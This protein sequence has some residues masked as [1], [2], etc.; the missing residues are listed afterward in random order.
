[1][2]R[3]TSA[4]ISLV[5]AFVLLITVA[6]A[7][8]VPDDTIVYITPTGTKYHREDCS[9]TTTVRSMTIKEAESRGFDPCSRCDPDRVVGSYSSNWDGSNSSSG[10]SSSN[11]E[12]RTQN[13]TI[14]DP[15]PSSKPVHKEEKESSVKEK[16]LKWTVYIFAGLCLWIFFVGPILYSLFGYIFGFV[17]KLIKKK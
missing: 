16:I 4:L 9:Y 15:S 2:K 7:Y 5:L 1:M 3:R 13:E 8:T 11:V 12:D 17:K 6:L 14:V 10:S